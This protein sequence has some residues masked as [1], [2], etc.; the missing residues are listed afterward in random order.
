MAE[1]ITA[2]RKEDCEAILQVLSANGFSEETTKRRLGISEREI[3]IRETEADIRKKVAEHK[4][5]ISELDVISARMR[6]QKAKALREMR[7]PGAK[8]PVINSDLDSSF[9]FLTP[10][11]IERA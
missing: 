9:E 2:A 11:N 3:S 5:A 10:Q 4:I 1:A 8:A 7:A 6:A